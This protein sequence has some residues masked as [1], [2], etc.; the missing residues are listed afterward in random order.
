MG[1]RA[2]YMSQYVTYMSNQMSNKGRHIF[3]E[4]FPLN[5][6]CNALKLTLQGLVNALKL[7]LQG[8]VNAL[9]LT[10]QGM[11]NALTMTFKVSYA[12]IYGLKSPYEAIQ[13]LI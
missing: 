5:V 2:T 11:V 10:L 8:M 3:C 1:I 7:T 4:K 6:T 12:D 13:S 9:K